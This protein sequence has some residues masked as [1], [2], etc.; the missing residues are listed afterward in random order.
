V[1]LPIDLYLALQ[2]QGIDA[3]QYDS[4]PREDID[5]HA[6]ALIESCA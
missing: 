5:D 1:P 2:D 3:K 4:P 6:P